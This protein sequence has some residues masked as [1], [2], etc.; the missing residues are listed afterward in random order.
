MIDTFHLTML[1]SGYLPV[2]LGTLYTAPAG[3]RVLIKTI[4][5][6]NE[7][8]GPRIINIYIAGKRVSPSDMNLGA[9]H[10]TVED[11]NHVLTGSSIISGDC[12]SPNKVSYLIEG[13]VS[14]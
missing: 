1:A 2:V 12:D 7:D 6:V 11:V 10:K 9:A 8:G 3:R 4:T 14:E 13:V 5:C